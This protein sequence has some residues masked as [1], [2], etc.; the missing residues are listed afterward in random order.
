MRRTRR[1]RSAGR[2][3][4]PR[5]SAVCGVA[6][7]GPVDLGEVACGRGAVGDL[8]AA[9]RRAVLPTSS[10]CVG[11]EVCLAAAL[12]CVGLASRGD[13]RLVVSGEG[14]VGGVGDALVEQGR[15]GAEQGVA[16]L[17]VVVEER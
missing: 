12:G 9:A 7:R 8:A 2:A 1:R 15:G 4:R 16:D 11:E 13:G 6:L 5:Q 3:E 10:P 14:D 17:D